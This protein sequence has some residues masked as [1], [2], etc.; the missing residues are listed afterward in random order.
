MTRLAEVLSRSSGLMCR[1]QASCASSSCLLAGLLSSRVSSLC[2]LH[3]WQVSQPAK[4]LCCL[5]TI[6]LVASAC[7]QLGALSWLALEWV[8][9]LSAG[10]ACC[11]TRPCL[12]AHMPCMWQPARWLTC[13]GGEDPRAQEQRGEGWQGQARALSCLPQAGGHQQLALQPGRAGCQPASQQAALLT[14]TGW[15]C[16]KLATLLSC[17]L[18][19]LPAGRAETGSPPPCQA[20]VAR[21]VAA[22]QQPAAATAKAGGA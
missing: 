19:S 13:P 20:I 3:Q 4:P 21:S 6:A 16:G 14:P 22:A 7:G 17:S 5:L 1:L 15:P 2:Q 12:L 10:L 11:L 9:C 18:G 8:G